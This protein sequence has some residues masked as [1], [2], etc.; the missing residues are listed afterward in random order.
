MPLSPNHTINQFCRQIKSTKNCHRHTMLQSKVMADLFHHSVKRRAFSGP[1]RVPFIRHK[2]MTLSFLKITG[3]QNMQAIHLEQLYFLNSKHRDNYFDGNR[4]CR[5]L[6][7]LWEK[8][9]HNKITGP[10][11]KVLM[12]P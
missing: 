5:I 8:I 4:S 1:R 6:W 9:W 2:T 7:L 10:H 12:K 11:S 3:P